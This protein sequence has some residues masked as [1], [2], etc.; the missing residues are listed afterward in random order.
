MSLSADS[1]GLRRKRTTSDR[2]AN[3]ADPLVVKKKAREA[4]KKDA[5]VPKNGSKLPSV[6]QHFFF[7]TVSNT[8][9]GNHCQSPSPFVGKHGLQ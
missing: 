8:I 7:R 9:I 3:N 4:N 6:S 1:L 2:A 5:T